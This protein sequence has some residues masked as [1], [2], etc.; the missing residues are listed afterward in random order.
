MISRRSLDLLAS[1]SLLASGISDLP[2]S[3]ARRHRCRPFVNTEDFIL[4]THL[5]Q[6]VSIDYSTDY[7]SEDAAPVRGYTN[8]GAYWNYLYLKFR[9]DLLPLILHLSA[10][11][12]I[13]FYDSLC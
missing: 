11:S 5:F 9:C 7:S 10:E 2:V 8:L 12:N 4:I 13:Y 6:I 1:I 3:L